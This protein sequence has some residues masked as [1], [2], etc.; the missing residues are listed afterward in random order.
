VKEYRQRYIVFEIESPRLVER[1]EFLAALQ[2]RASLLRLDLE[3]GGRPW[4]TAFHGNRGV[5]RCAHT[6]KEKAIEL[7]NGINEI[8]ENNE[9]KIAV[10]TISTSGTIKKAKELI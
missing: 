9:L 8:G 1:W 6:D 7:L 5:L 3:K 2:K 4:L 10:K